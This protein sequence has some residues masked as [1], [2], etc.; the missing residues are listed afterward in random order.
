[1]K[2][3]SLASLLVTWLAFQIFLG[4]AVPAAKPKVAVR[5]KVNEGIGKY[6]QQ[7]SL[8]KYNSPLGGP[9]VAGETY[10]FNVAVLSD[11]AD[12]VA[13]NHGQWCIKG[14]TDLTSIEYHGTLSGNDLVIEIPKKD[15]KVG[16]AN[17]VVYDHKWRKLADI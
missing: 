4:S 1:M 15:G 11:N 5:I 16:K 12:A 7:D 2:T 6:A 8:N 3:R 14:D 9:L 17:F 10:Y 13:T